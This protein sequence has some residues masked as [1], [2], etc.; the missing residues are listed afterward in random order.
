[1]LGRTRAGGYCTVERRLPLYGK[2]TL[3]YRFRPARNG[4]IWSVGVGSPVVAWWERSPARRWNVAGGYW[5]ADPRPEAVTSEFRSRWL[6]M[7]TEILLTRRVSEH[8][9]VRVGVE[10]APAV[11][12]I[13]VHPVILGVWDF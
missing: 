2:A 1:M 13:M 7:H 6:W 3:R 11:L 8:L 10:V 5:E 12:P 9:T 4:D